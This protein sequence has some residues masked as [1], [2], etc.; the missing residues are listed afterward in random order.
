[1]HPCVD[2]QVNNPRLVIEN[3]QLQISAIESFRCDAQGQ[4][5]DVGEVFGEGIGTYPI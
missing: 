3:G 5:G 1:M 2:K 4:Q